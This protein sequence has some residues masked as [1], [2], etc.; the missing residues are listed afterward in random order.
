MNTLCG[1][2]SFLV[3]TWDS[4]LASDV[5]DATLPSSSANEESRHAAAGD[6]ADPPAPPP[7]PPP[8]FALI[9]HAKIII[10]VVVVSCVVLDNTSTYYCNRSVTFC[11]LVDNNTLTHR[12]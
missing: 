11:L 4:L 7:T 12:A 2:R 9:F 1:R 8:L 6:P 10:Q 3:P 5:I